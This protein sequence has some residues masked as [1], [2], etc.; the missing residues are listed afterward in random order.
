DF[1]KVIELADSTLKRETK[2]LQIAAWFSEALSK[3]HGFAGLRD[4][5]KLL[6]GLQENFWDTLFPEID[7]GDMEGRANALAFVDKHASLAIK[8]QPIT[9]GRGLNYFQWEES[10]RF[11]IPEN[12]DTL[13]Y[14]DQQRYNELKQ[15]AE[16]ENRITGDM[17]RVAKAQT[18]RAFCEEIYFALEECWAEYQN[19]DRVIE[20]KFDRNQAPG[21]NGLKQ[22]L[23]DIRSQVKR[24]L[25][26]KRIEEP[27]PADEEAEG[28]EAGEETVGEDGTVMV[29]VAGKK[30][31]IQSRQ[32]ALKRLS[33][34]ADYFRKNEPHSP[35]S[36]LV[37]R[38]VKWGSMPL[39][40]WLQ[41]VI[42]DENVI[43]Q[44]RET[45]G[46]NM[47][48]ADGDGSDE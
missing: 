30:G 7:E 43:Y 45:L 23:D 48:S 4:G 36:Y 18:G 20:E 29:A 17:W 12:L 40:T 39:E 37:S 8:E 10:K 32:D 3:E 35:V 34:V 46:I 38:A 21:L 15:Q 1:R 19:L 5:L 24:L 33:E 27:D 47:T 13:D 9:G 31:P 11:D 41:D 26:E 16:T 2:D 25:D 44:L 6:S 22:S 42:K 28:E 14:G